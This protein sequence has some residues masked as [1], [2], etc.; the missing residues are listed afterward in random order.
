RFIGFFSDGKLKSIPAA[1]GPPTT[2]CSG[3]GLGFGGTWNRQGTIVFSAENGTLWRVSAS[4]SECT[5]LQIGI[6]TFRTAIPEFLPD[7]NHFFVVGGS[8]ADLS[9]VGLYV[10]SLDG[11]QPRRILKDNSSALY[12]PP[13]DGTSSG[14]LLFLRQNTLMAQAFDLNK[15]DVRG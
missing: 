13:A 10:S 11:M 9:T 6:D 14:H 1:G 2:L 8:S 4:G 5:S 7:G 15:L 3:A 12:A